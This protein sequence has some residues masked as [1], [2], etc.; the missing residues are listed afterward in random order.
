MIYG[1]EQGACLSGRGGESLHHNLCQGGV[2]LI[3]RLGVTSGL[4]R[5][6]NVDQR[7]R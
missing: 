3:A 7:D 2:V 4:A 5:R 6:V 1:E